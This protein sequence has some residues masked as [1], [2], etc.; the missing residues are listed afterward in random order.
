MTR[1]QDGHNSAEEV[2]AKSPSGK[3]AFAFFSFKM[4]QILLV[5]FVSLGVAEAHLTPMPTSCSGERKSGL[6]TDKPPDH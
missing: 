2:K 5:G 1:D 6:K 3:V 4:F